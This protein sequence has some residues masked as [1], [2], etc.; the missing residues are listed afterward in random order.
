MSVHSSECEE[1]YE[2]GDASPPPNTDDRFCLAAAE[3]DSWALGDWRIQSCASYIIF[4]LDET[5]VPV[6][7]LLPLEVGGLKK[8]N[9]P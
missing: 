8:M 7:L 5:Q 6:L 9:Q 4:A 2:T 3:T 1:Q